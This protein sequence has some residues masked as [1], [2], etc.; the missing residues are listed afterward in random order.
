MSRGG[1]P[2]WEASD[3]GTGVTANIQAIRR[4][5]CKPDRKPLGWSFTIGIATSAE[6]L[7]N[8]SPPSRRAM[9]PRAGF[10]SPTSHPIGVLVNL[11]V[12]RRKCLGWRLG[13]TGIFQNVGMA[14]RKDGHLSKR[15]NGGPERR[16]DRLER[17]PSHAKATWQAT[18]PSDVAGGG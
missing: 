2:P 16:A 12:W 13:K 18:V 6:R 4:A 10:D 9:K 5:R 8:A 17:Q 3:A 1:C 14:A 7:A 15:R 11:C